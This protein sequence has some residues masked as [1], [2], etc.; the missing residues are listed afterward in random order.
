MTDRLDRLWAG[1]R[2]DYLTTLTGDATALRPTGAGSLFERLLALGDDDEALVVTRGETCSVILN[3]YPYSCGH[4]MVVPNRAVED[5]AALND[6]EHTELWRLVRDG[7][8]A[9]RGAYGCGG[10]NVGA[11][12]GAAGGAGIP[13]HLHVHVVP[14]WEGDTNFMTTVAGVRVLP[15]ALDVTLQRVRAAWP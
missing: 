15:E 3:A 13:D 12:L 7:V 14:R 9:V 6:D 11:N 2:S 10:V 4:L 5:L 8:A 1:W